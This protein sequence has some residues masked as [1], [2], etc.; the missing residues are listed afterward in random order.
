MLAQ[1]GIREIEVS[2]AL[3]DPWGPGVIKDTLGSMVTK[4]RCYSRDVN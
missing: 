1:K 4:D 2:L 3:Q